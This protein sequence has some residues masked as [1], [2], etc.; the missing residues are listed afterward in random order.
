M[1]VTGYIHRASVRGVT[2]VL[3]F[4]CG[5]LAQKGAETHKL[6]PREKFKLELPKITVSVDYITKD[7]NGTRLTF[8][9]SNDQV[10]IGTIND[11]YIKN[12][13]RGSDKTLYSE[14]PEKA[15]FLTK[16]EIKY[17]TKVNK[18]F[19]K[20]LDLFDKLLQKKEWAKCRYLDGYFPNFLNG[21]YYFIGAARS[22]SCALPRA[23]RIPEQAY[24]VSLSSPK[25]DWRINHWQFN[26]EHIIK[27]R[28][29]AKELSYQLG[30]WQKL[31][32]KRKNN[33]DIVTPKEME[34]AF[35]IFVRLYFNLKPPSPIVVKKSR[36]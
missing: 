2:V 33:E 16:F 9:N 5:V 6:L 14:S 1:P 28:I 22:S 4:L 12:S 25:T 3:L 10:F 24:D 20:T 27:L 35:I 23:A 18:E 34:E 31:L 32:E 19:I 17:I 7:F 21:Y 11:M 8:S 36:K 30:V 13:S 26:P 29:S 15:S